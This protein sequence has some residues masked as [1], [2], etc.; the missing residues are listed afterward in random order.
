M[1]LNFKYDIDKDLSNYDN[2]FLN[3]KYPSY[4]REKLNIGSL[5][6]VIN[7]TDFGK[8]DFDKLGFIKENLESFYKKN[9]SYFDD[10]L[11]FVES[12]WQKRGDEYQKRLEKYFN[13]KIDFDATCY[14]TTLGIAPYNVD[15]KYFY[16][17]MTWSPARQITSI[18]HEYMHLVFRSNFDKY[19]TEK[20]MTQQDILEINEA[21]TVLINFEFFDLFIVP[22]QNNKPT[23]QDLRVKTMELW[24]EQKPFKEILEAVIQMRQINKT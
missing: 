3:H 20:G 11:K 24:E 1:K 6:P 14:L 13:V 18:A 17:I 22:D 16:S 4:G 12:E 10:Q 21:L 8:D 19:L 7:R 2:N 5:V 9:K 23:A 15:Q